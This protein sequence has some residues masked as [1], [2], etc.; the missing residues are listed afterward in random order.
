MNK[1]KFR[2]WLKEWGRA[3]IEEAQG[4]TLEE[5]AAVL[6][7]FYDEKGWTVESIDEYVKHTYSDTEIEAM[8]KPDPDDK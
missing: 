2:V 3:I 8:N 4:E 7:A 1:F 6:R 5:A